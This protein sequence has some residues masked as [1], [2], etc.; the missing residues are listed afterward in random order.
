MPITVSL[1]SR[2]VE[3]EFPDSMTEQEIQAAIDQEYPRSGEDVAFEVE[4]A[5]AQSIEG[6]NLVNP[7]QDMSRDDYILFRQNLANKKTSLGDFLGIAKDTFTNVIDEIGTGLGTAAYMTAQGELGKVAESTQEGIVAGTIGLADIASKILKPANK[8]PSKEE[9]LKTQIPTEM[10][11]RDTGTGL[12]GRMPQ[13]VKRPATEADYNALIEQEKQ[14]DVDAINRLYAIEATLKGAPVEE[15]A[16]GAQNIDPA[17]LTGLGSAAV[18]SLATKLAGKSIFKPAATA[19]ARTATA[20]GSLGQAAL[21]G[22]ERAA[23][24]VQTAASLPGQALQGIRNV[25]E[26]VAPGTGAA[27]QGTALATGLMADMGVT[28]GTLAGAATAEKAAEVVGAAAR[29]ARKEASRVGLLEQAAQDA[30][31]SPAARKLA[32]GL[33][34]LQPVFRGASQAAA[35][36]LKEGAAG[37]A[38]GAGLGYLAERNLE[39]AAQGAGA[40]AAFGGLTGTMRS[41]FD[42]GREMVGGST[43]RTR[44]QAAGDLNTFLAERP[45]VEQAAWSQTIN[46]L[47][48][49]V[50]PERAA[51][52]FDAMK[53]AEANGAKVRVATPDEMKQWQNPGWLDVSTQEVVLNPNKIL[54]DTA[55]H[56]T[57]HV[58]FSSAINRAF[59]PEIEQAVFGLADPVTGEIVRPGLFDDVALAKIA[60]QIGDAYGD[61]TKAA[62]EFKGYANVLRNTTDAA[63]LQKARTSIA[64][65]MAAAY[66]GNLFG[67][68]R[69]GRFNPD[70][71]PLVYRNALNA[72]EDSILD[73]FRSVLFEKGMDL[74]FDSVT[75]TFKDAKGKPIRIPEL[76]A[77]VKRALAKRG[78]KAAQAP[79]AKPDLI[80]V[81]PADRAIWAR[82]YGGA[83]GILNDDNTPKTAAQIQAEA[84]AR[85]QDM[86]QR[87]AAL[88]ETERKGIEFN[89]DST[90]K[91]VMTAKGQLSPE[92]LNV[93]LDSG[94]LDPSAKAV[95]RD[96]LT[97][98]QN[99]NKA[100]FDTRYYGVYDRGIGRSKMVAGVKSVSQNEILPYSVE[101]NSKEGV[102]IR[103]VDMTK[104]R[105]R[106]ATALT[107]PQF[108]D[109]Y[110]SSEAALKD[111]NLYLENITQINPVD[112]ATLLGGGEKGAKKRNLFY[113]ALGFRLRNNESLLN[114]PESVI[115]KSQNTVKSY[116]VER[117]AKLQDSGNRFAF[118]EA[119]T[120]ERAMKNFQ[121]DAFARETLPAGETLTNPDGYRI[122]KKAGSKLYRVYDDKGELIGTTSTEKAAMRKGQDDFAKK[123]SQEE[124]QTRFQPVSPEQD[125]A[126][127]SAVKAGDTAT[128]QALV[129]EAAKKAGYGVKAFHSTKNP[130]QITQFLTTAR[131]A[132][133]AHFGLTRRQAVGPL[134]RHRK[135]GK[136]VSL[137]EVYLKASNPIRLE[138]RGTW[139]SDRV[140]PQINDQLKSSLPNT[141][142]RAEIVS[143]LREN[144]YD[145]AI[146]ENRF[147]GKE[148]DEAVI[149][150]NPNQIKSADPVTYDDAGNVIP[151][152]QRFNPESPDIRFQP[153]P[154]DSILIP[155]RA[156]DKETI[157]LYQKTEKGIPVFDKKKPKIVKMDYNLLNKEMLS[158]FK[159][160]AQDLSLVSENQFPYEISKQAIKDIN[161]AIK[162]GIVDSL[163]NKIVA[164][165]K[166]MLTDTTIAAGRG[167]YSRMRVALK[168]AYGDL[169]E[170]FAQLLGATS[171][172]T[173][174]DQNFL[175]AVEAAELI[176][177]GSFDRH[178][179]EYLTM[180]AAQ[181]KGT[182]KQLIFDRNLVGSIRSE[183]QRLTPILKQ[184]KSKVDRE[185]LE[186][187]ILQLKELID[188]P[189]DNWSDADMRNIFILGEDILPRRKNGKKFNANSGAVLAVIGGDWLQTVK[190]PKTP[191]FAGN[192]TGRTLEA[193]IDV[194]AARFMRR[195]IYGDRGIPWRIQYAAE[196][197]VSDKDFAFSQVVLKRAAR[198]LDMNPDDL[199][200][201]L[202]FGEKD[203]YG[204]NNW[205]SS[206]G[207]KKSS[208]DEMFY[209]FFPKGGKPRTYSEVIKLLGKVED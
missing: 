144:G 153:A 63:S 123:A 1:P 156:L 113:D 91:T 162:S 25:A 197:G 99:F 8:I 84:T 73:K 48:E 190:A 52:Q 50:G 77:I 31:I 86:T 125:A 41:V 114:A 130:R 157:P 145:S 142:S 168:K 203:I 13:I 159:G 32:G 16:R 116:R 140:V 182:L 154:A 6:G 179:K 198:K 81:N 119:T 172:Q 132:L 137:Y 143:F 202:W 82:S 9:F 106:L 44:Q 75:R 112:S 205:T 87:M 208:F 101:M 176:K 104:V 165:T 58:L 80:P 93:I 191:N 45:E 34:Q 83:R 3:L 46:R 76:D 38:V 204:K 149:L 164:E 127:L 95:L 61:N 65:E 94:T 166:T 155:N 42:M 207:K 146:Y 158:N 100:T 4:Q 12:V 174:V 201:V 22:I 56:E 69:P 161:D 118:E 26:R 23:G 177:D 126:Y 96:V 39:G 121:P 196:K 29:A 152:S 128:A 135:V 5:K 28:A 51:A 192:L 105:D 199:Q 171:A 62:N 43:S 37:A 147:E 160:Q 47:V 88:P 60:D 11:S 21:S 10:V 186:T 35:Q 131:D 187:T 122:L 57:S 178:R 79:T 117:F 90:G 70:R 97:S 193:T 111:F 134:G 148:G 129:D 194:W 170:V 151:L 175:Q 59:K 78:T 195:M 136:G 139:S 181:E 67:R 85:W 7:F 185:S 173:P 102:I 110:A 133:G 200:A 92:A 20:P 180:R 24:G 120:Y 64:D 109:V 2:D 74:G 167:W 169:S 15:I 72:L 209:M 184:V 19:A 18:R 33:A 189:S 183:I 36:A 108:K 54:G 107:K 138:D 68:L 30:A 188:N 66:T 150:F 53:I 27:A 141:A 55:A 89:R 115:S 49:Q 14:R 71:L 98:M 124:R 17:I 163:V 206:E 103:A 40:G